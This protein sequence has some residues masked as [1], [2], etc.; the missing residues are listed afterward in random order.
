[1]NST[2]NCIRNHFSENPTFINCPRRFTQLL[3]HQLPCTFICRQAPT[4]NRLDFSKR[5]FRT[6][7]T[8]GWRSNWI[9]ILIGCKFHRL[10]YSKII[11]MKYH[12]LIA[13]YV[14]SMGSELV[15][16][17]DR[18]EQRWHCRSLKVILLTFRR[19]IR[20]VNY[21]LLGFTVM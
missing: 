16:L 14:Q 20:L 19:Q 11:S 13:T 2:A 4:F 5:N 18:N 7:T 12:S 6:G 9:L 21:Y 10:T 3:E 17:Y 8:G 15:H 1:M